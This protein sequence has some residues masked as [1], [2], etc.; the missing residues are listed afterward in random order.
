MQ[1]QT[2]IQ[3]ALETFFKPFAT[4]KGLPVIYEATSAAPTTDHFEIR[5]FPSPVKDPSLGVAHRRYTGIFRILYYTYTKDKGSAAIND[6][7]GEIATLFKRGTAVVKN[8]ITVNIETTP[9]VSGLLIEDAYLY[10][11]IDVSY[12]CD[13]MDY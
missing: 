10:K 7:C 8:G 11:V 9:S 4:A 13:I 12:R 3:V 5:W 1:E 2:K 6:M